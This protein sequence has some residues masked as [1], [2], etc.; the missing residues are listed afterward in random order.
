MLDQNV[1]YPTPK[2]SRFGSF[3]TGTTSGQAQFLSYARD[4]ATVMTGSAAKR[5]SLK[6]LRLLCGR[7]GNRAGGQPAPCEELSSGKLIYKIRTRPLY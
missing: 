6:R 1:A 3:A 7:K 2:T 5:T 4:A